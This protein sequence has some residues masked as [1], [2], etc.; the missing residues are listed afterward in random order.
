M[1]NIYK[2]V[3]IGIF[4]AFVSCNE[5]KNEVKLP[6]YVDTNKKRIEIKNIDT[7][8]ISSR[9]I[10][11]RIDNII[12]GRYCGECGGECAT[13][14][15]YD[16]L[17]NKLLVDH[18]DS[19]FK[20]RDNITFANNILNKNKIDLVVKIIDSIPAILYS[21]SNLRDRYGCPDCADGCGIYFEFKLGKIIR[22][23]DIDYQ[24]SQLNGEIKIFAEF[25]KRMIKE[26]EK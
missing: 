14:Y 4:I 10:N 5:N 16:Y 3:V 9:I 15:K 20:N 8:T 26:V 19:Y 21:N 23:Y 22:K 13:M 7:T 11:A 1:K 17:R 24:T 12:F 2:I 18:S 6:K 25:L